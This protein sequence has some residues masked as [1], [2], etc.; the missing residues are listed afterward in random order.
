[1][2]VSRSVDMPDYE[3]QRQGLVAALQ[4]PPIREAFLRPE[5]HVVFALYEWSGEGVQTIIVPWTE[6]RSGAD[7]DRMIEAVA[8]HVRDERRLATALGEA[9][10]FGRALLA[11][12]PACASYTL[13]IS[14]DGQNN[15]G[16]EPDR[17][18][19]GQDF[20]GITVNGLAIGEH[21]RGLV[22]YYE[23]HVIHGPGAFVVP[24]PHQ[25]DFPRAIRVKLEKELN[26]R[27]I[28][29]VGRGGGS[30]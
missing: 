13:D 3:I 10:S 7:I 14:G 19:A 29:A 17:I 23:R 27:L 28:G 9:I 22:D 11:E 20:G 16:P 5:G 18:Y 21:E 30:G 26:V 2:D 15:Q 1:M 12:A 8:T 24:A 6:V 4:S 25:R